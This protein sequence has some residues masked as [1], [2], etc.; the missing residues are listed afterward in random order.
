MATLGMIIGG[1]IGG[2]LG[3]AAL[4]IAGS[5]YLKRAAVAKRRLDAAHKKLERLLEKEQH[6]LEGLKVKG[7]SQLKEVGHVEAK[8]RALEQALAK[9]E[10]RLAHKKLKIAKH[11]IEL[12]QETAKNDLVKH[13]IV[14]DAFKRLQELL[15]DE[16]MDE[17]FK[18]FHIEIDH[19]RKMVGL[20]YQKGVMDMDTRQR[21]E[22]QAIIKNIHTQRHHLEQANMEYH[23][24]SIE[25]E[26][27]AMHLKSFYAAVVEEMRMLDELISYGLDKAKT[28]KLLL[29][30]EKKLAA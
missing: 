11:M 30:R 2:V 10:D 19:R 28:E 13:T 18:D 1:S 29:Q 15:T 22:V 7:P 26:R 20:H 5:I 3:V 24:S 21:L 27:A 4:I 8:I 16:T 25:L 12:F 9:K 14:M 17:L 23:V 6:L